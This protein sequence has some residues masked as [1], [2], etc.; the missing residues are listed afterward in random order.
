MDGKM[1]YRMKL[2]M[3]KTLSDKVG[4][5]PLVHREKK[6]KNSKANRVKRSF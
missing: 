6:T 5:F 3:S 4:E 1:N 2:V